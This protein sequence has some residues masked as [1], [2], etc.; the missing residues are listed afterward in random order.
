MSR[1]DTDA[2]SLM[3][4]REVAELLRVSPRWIELTVVGGGFPSPVRIP[5]PR[6]GRSLRRWR[7]ADVHGWCDALHNPPAPEG[8]QE[9]NA[10]GCCESESAPMRNEAH[11]DPRLT[12]LESDASGV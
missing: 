4:L 5:N 10:A 3:N 7:R 9:K 1:Y 11:P 2:R 12:P 6:G 8:R